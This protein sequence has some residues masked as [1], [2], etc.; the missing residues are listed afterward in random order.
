MA[1]KG[2]SRTEQRA[3]A[4]KW[5]DAFL[6]ALSLNANVTQSAIA[7]GVSRSSVYLHRD[8][9][10]DFKKAWD[11]AIEQAV[12]RLEAEAWRRAFEGTTEPIYSQGKYVADRVV[13]SDG[14]MTTLLKAHRP[15][16]YKDR[17]QQ[18]VTGK[19]GK[20]LTIAVVKMDVNEL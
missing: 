19:D 18:E 10:E 2:R 3:P 11:D 17:S 15:E 1:N 5:I 7:A 14:L 9:D 8:A 13:Y 4:L 12:D 16:K 6:A 20:A